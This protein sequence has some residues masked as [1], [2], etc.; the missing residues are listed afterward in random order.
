[1]IWLLD[2]TLLTTFSIIGI[3][4]TTA[5]YAVP[6]VLSNLFDPANWNDK[7]EQEFNET[8]VALATTW[9]SL[10][11]LWT[12]WNVI[13]ATRPKLYSGLLL[14]I[15]VVLAWIGNLFNN[16][17]L[18][19]LIVL[20]VALYPGLKTHGIIEKHLGKLIASVKEKVGDNLKQN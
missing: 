4:L 13:K 12:E 8:C 16:L 9:K 14:S 5:D 17:F 1:L 7:K 15:L 11:D 20:F 2:A 18:T 6:L 3:I 10:L 19:Y